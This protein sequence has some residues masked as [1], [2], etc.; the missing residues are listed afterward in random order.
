MIYPDN[1]E[2]EHLCNVYF[3]I[4]AGKSTLYLALWAFVADNG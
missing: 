1:N 4:T 2:V 3:C